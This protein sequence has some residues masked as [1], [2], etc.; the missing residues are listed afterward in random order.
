MHSNNLPRVSGIFEDPFLILT[1]M[2]CPTCAATA[3]RVSNLEQALRCIN[4]VHP[5]VGHRVGAT[6]TT[7]PNMARMRHLNRIKFLRVLK[8]AQLMEETTRNEPPSRLDIRNSRQA[9]DTFRRRYTEYGY[10]CLQ[11][12]RI[13]TCISSAASIKYH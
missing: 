11:L 5:I 2:Q 6:R 12:R 4:M 9:S 13:Y 10:Q 7:C 1:S 8:D 3:H